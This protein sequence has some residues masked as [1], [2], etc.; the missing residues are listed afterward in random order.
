VNGDRSDQRVRITDVGP[1]QTFSWP[2][3]AACGQPIEEARGALVDWYGF[4]DGTES[5]MWLVHTGNCWRSLEAAVRRDAPD[6]M[7]RDIPL[8]V[9]LVYWLRNLELLDADGCVK[10]E[11]MERARFFSG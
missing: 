9:Y 2:L 3:C 10:P 4:G 7:L 6:E 8:D 11:V 1:G 5:P